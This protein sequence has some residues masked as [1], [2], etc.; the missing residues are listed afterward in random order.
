MTIT[1]LSPRTHPL[2]PRQLIGSGAPLPDGP[3]RG[4]RRRVLLYSHDGFGLGHLRRNTLI[5]AALQRADPS[6]RATLVTGVAAD[7]GWAEARGLD[8]LRL[9][10]LLKD[11]TGV[12]RAGHMSPEDAIA[13]R[14]RLFL[15]AVERQ[16]P[17]LVVVDR[18]PYGTG[19]ELRPGLERA[20]DQG[21]VLVL[22]LRDVLDEPA[23]IRAEIDGPRWDG[24]VD[25]F[26][27]VLVYG[28][29]RLV[30]HQR[31]YGLPV[32]PSYMGWVAAPSPAG[33]RVRRRLAVA[34]GGGADGTDAFRLGME[35]VQRRPGWTCVIA[36]G[37]YTGASDGLLRSPGGRLRVSTDVGSCSELYASSEAVL[38]MAGYNS[39]V[40]ALGAGIRPILLPRRRPRREQAI[41][42]SRLAAWGLADV[43][44]SGAAVDEVDWYL[45]QPRTV[46]PG[47]LAR[48]GITFDGADRTAARLGVLLAERWAA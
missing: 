32:A 35:L 8:V 13:V 3:G 40:E 2:G 39:T 11:S 9:P 44:D 12:Y 4:R 22:G 24:A 33:R 6:V 21:A 20:A 5:A 28:S 31:E 37:P 26:D 14:A 43:V 38:Q 29:P 10:A 18:H 17:D 36:A 46:S 23:V 45:D 41:R 25:L 34:A 42:A 48:A 27:E 1:E 16:R 19:G 30:D 47:A 15:D 7:P